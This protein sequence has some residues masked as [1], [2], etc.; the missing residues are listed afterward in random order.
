MA[1][2]ASGKVL[3]LLMHCPVTGYR[4]AL[5]APAAALFLPGTVQMELALFLSSAGTVI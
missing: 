5:S 3:P 4:E 1:L 2:L